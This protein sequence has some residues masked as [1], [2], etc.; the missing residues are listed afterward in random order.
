MQESFIELNKDKVIVKLVTKSLRLDD[1]HNSLDKTYDLL[2]K[3]ILDIME[4]SPLNYR[5]R[6]NYNLCPRWLRKDKTRR[7]VHVNI[8]SSV[9]PTAGDISLGTIRISH[10]PDKNT[11]AFD[12]S[13]IF[14]REFVLSFHPSSSTFF[15]T[16]EKFYNIF[17]N[18]QRQPNCYN[19]T[20]MAF[21]CTK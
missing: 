16:S 17:N 9:F 12:N 3:D 8:N 5:V 18:L 11:Y 19:S 15:M 13:H 20:K 2:L 10:N 21:V 1:L 14:E 4:F 6:K 7:D